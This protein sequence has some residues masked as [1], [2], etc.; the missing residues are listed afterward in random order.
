METS[1]EEISGDQSGPVDARN[2]SLVCIGNTRKDQLIPT[3]TSE[4]YWGTA[5]TSR[6]EGRRGVA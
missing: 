1:M 2:E 4:D 3:D 6:T 5:E